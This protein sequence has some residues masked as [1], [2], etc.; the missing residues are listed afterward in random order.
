SFRIRLPPPLKRQRLEV[1][2]RRTQQLALEAKKNSL[3]KALTD[4]EKLI[5]SKRDVFEVSSSGL[6]AYRARAIQSCLQMVV[7]NKRKLIDASERAAESQG[8]AAKWGGRLVRRWVQG[9]WKTRQLPVSKRGRHVK[10]Y[11]LLGDPSICAEMRSYVRSN[12]WAMDPAKLAEFSQQTMVPAAAEAYAKQIVKQEIPQGLKR[13]LELELFPRIHF[14]PGRGISLRTARRWLHREGFRFMEHKKA[15]WVLEGEQPLKKKGQGRGMHQ[16]EVIC[17]TVGW[18]TDAGQSME[19]GKNYEGYWTGEL[20]VKQVRPDHTLIL[21]EKIIPVFERV[22]GPGYQ[23]LI[24]VDN[25]QGHSAYAE[26]AL[27]VS[28]M[29]LKPGGK[30]ARLRDGWFMRDGQRVPQ[31]MNFPANHRDNPG[32]QKGIRQFHCELNFIEFFWGAVKRYLRENCDYTFNTLK[33]NLPKA[34]ASVDI[35][36]IRRW[37]HRTVRWT[38]AYRSGLGVKEAQFEV[39]R[40]SSKRYTSHRRVPETLARQFDK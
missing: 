21:K 24:M 17:S 4:I 8:F 27:L 7:H 13:Y 35:K 22:H 28:R 3:H 40:F 18:L 15:S 32:L 25:S 5:R 36:T 26:D 29:N 39:K 2:A 6:Q 34:M 38:E 33:E 19:Y 16:S 9:W 20:F 11:T 23:A 14:K 31:Q 30:Q 1:P 12:K 37:E 10:V